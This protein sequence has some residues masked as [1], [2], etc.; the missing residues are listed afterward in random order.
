MW[1]NVHLSAH[2][3]GPDLEVY[4]QNLYP[5]G[6]RHL[7]QT[8]WSDAHSTTYQFNHVQIVGRCWLLV[9]RL[10]TWLHNDYSIQSIVTHRL[11]DGKALLLTVFSTQSY[12]VLESH[13]LSV[14]VMSC[15]KS[16]NG[17]RNNGHHIHHYRTTRYTTYTQRYITNT[18]RIRSRYLKTPIS[19]YHTSRPWLPLL[20]TPVAETQTNSPTNRKLKCTQRSD[21]MRPKRSK[22][23][24]KT[25]QAT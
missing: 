9:T 6:N 5:S 17:C 8:R 23:E 21:R 10:T 7:I 12:I 20:T 4:A 14:R 16:D 13:A 19:R 15:I 3:K 24:G 22:T 11:R 1:I 2:R 25:L 18:S